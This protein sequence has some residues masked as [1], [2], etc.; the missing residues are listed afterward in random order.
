[1]SVARL[2]LASMGK[3]MFP[4]LEFSVGNLPVPPHPF[5]THGPEAA[6]E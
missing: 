1:M 4:F 5:P 3:T 6:H 2:R